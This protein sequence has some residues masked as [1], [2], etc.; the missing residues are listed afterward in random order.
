V[1]DTAGAGDTFVAT[2]IAAGVLHG[3]APDQALA[4]A[5]K[6]AAI[7]IG[8]AGTRA[9]FPTRDE[10]A[11]ILG[12]HQPPLAQPSTLDHSRA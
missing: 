10:M 1:V 2:L 4:A 8:R 5:T 3:A 11:G 7:T 12:K 9:S 6:A